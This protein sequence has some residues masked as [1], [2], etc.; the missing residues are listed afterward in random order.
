MRQVTRGSET[1]LV[2][3]IAIGRGMPSSHP[4]LAFTSSKLRSSGSASPALDAVSPAEISSMERRWLSL[5]F[6][7]AVRRDSLA[8]NQFHGGLRSITTETIAPWPHHH[9]GN[10]TTQAAA[11][12]R[13]A[14]FF[15]VFSTPFPVPTTTDW[16]AS[17]S[18]T[19]APH[20]VVPIMA[21]GREITPKN[22]HQ[23][24]PAHARSG[25]AAP[26]RHTRR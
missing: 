17:T 25:P 24:E 13:S 5:P 23:A 12:P 9:P 2:C 6:S 3:T 7:C 20:S 26:I 4:W 14:S 10:A 16:L 11:C 19:P 8:M 22:E 1:D 18:R 15:R 21:V